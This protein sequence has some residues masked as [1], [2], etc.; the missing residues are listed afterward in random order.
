M[1]VPEK[2]RKQDIKNIFEEIM[3]ENFPYLV[4]EIDLQVQEAQKVTNKRNPKRTTLRHIMIKM[5]KRES[6]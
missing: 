5:A 1:G 6:R 3:T 4:K 2:E